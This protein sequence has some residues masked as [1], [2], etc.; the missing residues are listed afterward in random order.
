MS[1]LASQAVI[2]IDKHG[3]IL[4]ANTNLAKLFGYAQN[5]LVGFKVNKL[6]ASPF[7]E[8]H[9]SYL[10]RY[11]QTKDPHILGKSRGKNKQKKLIKSKLMHIFS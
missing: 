5:E 11:H 1:L 10:T 9:D 8:Q 2:T 7:A 6:M 3:T 4:S